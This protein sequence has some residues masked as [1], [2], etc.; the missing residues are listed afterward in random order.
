MNEF[1]EVPAS[2]NSI[3]QRKPVFG[4]G[5]ND[6][7]Y[8]IEQ[9]INGKQTK[10]PYYERWKNML[11]RCYS[12]KYQERQPTYIE[13]TV[14]EE[15]LTFS[16]FKSWMRSKCWK[17]NHLDKDLKIQGN[18]IYS[19]DTCLFVPPAVNTFTTGSDAKRGLHPIGVYFDKQ[20]GKF[21][22]RCSNGKGKQKYLGCFN[23]PEEAHQAWRIFKKQ[24]GL[25]LANEQTNPEIKTA[26]IKYVE[27]I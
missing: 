16:N 11:M 7:D 21:Q 15:W 26:L 25:E 1:K 4:V 2:N 6:A 18:K 17:E 3:A 24:L 23:S 20:K 14:C 5:I 9:R 19:P 12:S 13:C 10:C 22:A 27:S 8:L